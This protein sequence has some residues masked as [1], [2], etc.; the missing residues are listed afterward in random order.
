MISKV[1]KSTSIIA[2]NIVIGGKKRHIKFDADTNGTG[3]FITSDKNIIRC[4]D[5]KLKEGCPRYYLAETIDSEAQVQEEEVAP[6]PETPIIAVKV[7][8]IIDAKEYLCSNF[9]DVTR[10]SLKTKKSI[11]E[12]AESH[13]IQFLGL[14][15]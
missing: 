15:P 6:N 12:A 11:F 3:Y 13:N 8:N 9:D 14:E 10:S 4:L 1:Y 7:G 5:K 2:V